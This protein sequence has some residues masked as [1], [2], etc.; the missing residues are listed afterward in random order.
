MA[1]PA[2]SAG[3]GKAAGGSVSIHIDN[4]NVRAATS[5][6]QALAGSVA[7]ELSRILEGVGVTIGAR[8][9]PAGG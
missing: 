9:A 6:P 7:A 2:A 1:A 4:L 5:E 8:M 3:A